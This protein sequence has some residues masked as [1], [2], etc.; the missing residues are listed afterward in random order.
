ML[1]SALRKS[2]KKLKMEHLCT[3]AVW[4]KRQETKD[5]GVCWVNLCVKGETLHL[6]LVGL[7][8]FK[9]SKLLLLSTFHSDHMVSPMSCPAHRWCQPVVAP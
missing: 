1:L 8:R 6:S 9:G 3:R 5:I 2:T 7:Q 4:I